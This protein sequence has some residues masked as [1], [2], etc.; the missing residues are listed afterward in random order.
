MFIFLLNKNGKKKKIKF[1]LHKK[2]KHKCK[3]IIQTKNYKILR[4]KKEIQTIQT[5]QNKTKMVRR[6]KGYLKKRKFIQSKTDE[7]DEKLN[8]NKGHFFNTTAKNSSKWEE[9]RYNKIKKR[10]T[11]KFCD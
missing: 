4:Q 11:L 7:K 5:Y 10:D 3:E 6:A 9:Y 2:K 1:K 8:V